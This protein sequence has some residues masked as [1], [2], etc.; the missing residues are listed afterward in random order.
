MAKEFDELNDFMAG[1]ADP[2]TRRRIGAEL[3]NPD[4]SLRVFL[5]GMRLLGN[6]L[7]EPAPQPPSFTIFRAV[8]FVTPFAI[9]CGGWGLLVTW[10]DNRVFGSPFQPV[11]AAVLLI[12]IFLIGA[13]LRLRKTR[14]P[15]S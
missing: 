2:E 7:L 15:L 6:K 5:D 14:P 13:T 4:S 1:R 8:A 12:A 9:L 3:E 11:R 10:I